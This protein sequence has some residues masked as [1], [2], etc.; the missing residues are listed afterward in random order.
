MIKKIIIVVKKVL[1][2]ALV[3]YGLNMILSSVNIF[4]PIN[5]STIGSV[6]L[7]GIPGYVALLLMYFITK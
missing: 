3:I 4:I 2:A 1:F 5:I 7:L 6:T